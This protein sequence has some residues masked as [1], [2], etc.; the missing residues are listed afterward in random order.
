MKAQEAASRIKEEIGTTIAM[1][2]VTGQMFV[3]VVKGGGE[4]RGGLSL[5]LGEGV[6]FDDSSGPY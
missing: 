2:F 6:F 5:M 4:G 3:K 1:V